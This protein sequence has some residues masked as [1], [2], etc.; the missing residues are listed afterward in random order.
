MCGIAG[1]VAIGDRDSGGAYSWNS[2]EGL[3]QQARVLWL[4]RRKMLR[5]CELTWKGCN[6]KKKAAEAANREYEVKLERLWKEMS[7]GTSFDGQ[8]GGGSADRRGTVTTTTGS[9]WTRGVSVGGGLGRGLFDAPRS[10]VQ[11][12]PAECPPYVYIAWERRFGVFIANQG[13]VTLSPL[14]LLK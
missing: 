5:L 4:Y 11:K 6:G 1:T 8:G 2:A 9:M 3:G 14:T 7:L 10:V 12:F 13:L